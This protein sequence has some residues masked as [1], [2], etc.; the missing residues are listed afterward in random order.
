MSS[1]SPKKKK[2][3]FF[4]KFSSAFGKR[5]ER[6]ESGNESSSEAEEDDEE[7]RG[8]NWHNRTDSNSSTSRSRSQTPMASPRKPATDVTTTK[9]SKQV[10]NTEKVFFSAAPNSEEAPTSGQSESPISGETSDK[11]YE[12]KKLFM[13]GKL[14][15]ETNSVDRSNS[16]NEVIILKE[17]DRQLH[18][19]INSTPGIDATKKFVKRLRRTETRDTSDSDSEDWT[20]DSAS[21][22]SDIENDFILAERDELDYGELYF[23]KGKYMSYFFLQMERQ[24][25]DPHEVYSIVRF[26]KDEKP[27][28]NEAKGTRETIFSFF[29]FFSFYSKFCL[30]LSCFS[31]FS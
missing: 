13:Q 8:E 20:T 30:N 12:A 16:D 27:K 24:S 22:S 15:K 21:E 26:R 5:K 28:G 17:I 9:P 4:Q 7:R 11:N 31:R 3:T 25:Y 29:F 1:T 2:K 18:D 23:T 19:A 6:K 14:M 10:E